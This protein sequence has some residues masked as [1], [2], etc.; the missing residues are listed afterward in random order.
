M[1]NVIYES[2][3]GKIIQGDNVEV[4]K[5]FKENAIHSCI[6]DFPY[7]LKFMGKKWDTSENFYEWCKLR[8]EELY[9]VMIKGGYVLIFG[10][11][12]TNH[13]MKCAFEDVGFKIVEEIDWI[14]ATGFPK[15]QDI[16]KMFD[17]K[18][19]VENERYVIG[20]SNSKGIRSGENNYVGDDY[21]CKGY[22]ITTAVSELGIKWDG[23][24]TS[25]LKPAKEPITVFQK[26]LEKNYCYNIEKYSCGAM[27]INACRIGYKDKDDLEKT[28]AKCNFTENSKSI[29]FGTVDSLYGI[30]K[31]PLDQARQCVNNNGRFPANIIFDTYMGEI[32]DVQS[33]IT[34]SDNSNRKPRKKY[35]TTEYKF[36]NGTTDGLV[37]KGFSD[38]GGASRYFLSIDTSEYV[39]FYYCPKATKK[40]K[41]KNNKHVTVK[42]KELIKWLIKLV[43][44]KDGIT[45]DITAGSGT[46]GLACE[47]LNRDE[48]YNL[49]W[50]N[51]E[52]MNTEKE[53]YCDIAKERIEN[54]IEI[55]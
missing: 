34:Q 28:K 14:Y 25:G 10:H 38:V 17:K 49:K 51:I 31:T 20:K 41:G 50:I 35:S 33:G 42:P 55:S 30:G 4:L 6:S 52:M 11:H 15:N 16:G 22:N 44:P 9:R 8:A 27:N 53:P 37:T 3:N 12:K 36:G 23:W 45:I 48:G 21:K 5:T 26:P 39:P 29:G 47:E 32:L 24:K 7:N 1:N 18:Y 43:T 40:E 2:K 13:R 19:G 54:V 46:H